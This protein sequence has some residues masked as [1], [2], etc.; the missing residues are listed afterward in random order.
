MCL[1]VEE[2]IEEITEKKCPISEKKLFNLENTDWMP[3]TMH[4]ENPY[5]LPWWKWTHTKSKEER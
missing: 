5:P 1:W 2:E 3:M 4:E